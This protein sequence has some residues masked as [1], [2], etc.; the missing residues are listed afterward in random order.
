MSK[1]FTFAL[2]TFAALAAFVANLP[3]HANDTGTVFSPAAATVIETSDRWETIRRNISPKMQ[4]MHD[5]KGFRIGAPI[6]MRVFK[7]TNE[8]EVW[9]RGP[10]ARYYLFK[11]YGVC[12]YSG[13]LGPKLKQ[14]DLQAPEGIYHVDRHSLNPNSRYHLSFDLG[15]PNA[16]DQMLGRTGKYLMI[17]G[18][19]QSVGCYAMSN[20]NIEEIYFLAEAALLHSQQLFWVHVFPFRMTDEK[21]EALRDEKWQPFWSNLKQAYDYFEDYQRPPNVGIAKGAYLFF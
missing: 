3:N 11:T 9:M 17:H 15:F 6:F 19:C 20:N 8:L 18:D 14:G 4:T 2:A 21:M 12:K 16:Y 5:T 1:Y 13:R 7:E 10:G